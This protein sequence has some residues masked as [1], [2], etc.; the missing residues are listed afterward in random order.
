MFHAYFTK[1]FQ[2]FTFL[3]QIFAPET[4]G[5]FSA[6]ARKNSRTC[7]IDALLCEKL[8]DLSFVLP[9]MEMQVTA[10]FP[11]DD[12]EKRS[13]EATVTRYYPSYSLTL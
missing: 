4:F 6:L 13:F 11:V 8:H 2:R 12:L 3:I 1:R 10:T 7:Y 9:A 5:P